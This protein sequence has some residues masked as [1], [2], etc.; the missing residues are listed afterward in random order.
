M[1]QG[2]NYSYVRIAIGFFDG[3][4][5][6]R[7][8]GHLQKAI[9][10]IDRRRDGQFG[11][12]GIGKDMDSVMLNTRKL[13]WPDQIADGFLHFFALKSSFVPFFGASSLLLSP[14]LRPSIRNGHKVQ[15]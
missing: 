10:A 6:S 14:K 12:L 1:Q 4:T 7:L 2:C 9:E 5:Y 8:V 13:S 3:M 15:T 11:I